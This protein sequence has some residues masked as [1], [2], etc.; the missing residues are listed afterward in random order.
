MDYTTALP[1]PAGIARPILPTP[2][3]GSRFPRVRA[4]HA[5]R[6]LRSGSAS[7]EVAIRGRGLG[8]GREVRTRLSGGYSDGSRSG[9]G[10]W[11]RHG[12]NEARLEVLTPTQVP[13]VCDQP[14]DQLCYRRLAHG[15]GGQTRCFAAARRI[16]QSLGLCPLSSE[17]GDGQVSL[18]RSARV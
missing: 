14:D 1:S 6:K 12:V 8:G 2:N 16:W 7:R 9:D 17:K 3:I 10:G 11:I 13:E 15:L 4:A 18:R 5:C